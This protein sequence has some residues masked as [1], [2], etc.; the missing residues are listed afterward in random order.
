[1]QKHIINL[2]S[3]RKPSHTPLAKSR[4]ENNFFLCIPKHFFKLVVLN[5]TAKEIY[6]LCNRIT[7]SKII[8]TMKKRYPNE[9]P[10]KIAKAVLIGLR[11]LEV[12]HIINL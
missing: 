9:D 5:S 6:E 11:D 12:A 7:V 8:N 1:M 3:S 2:L 10:E 4:D